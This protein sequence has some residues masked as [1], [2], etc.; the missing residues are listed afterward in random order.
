MNRR[1]KERLALAALSQG[2]MT[3]VREYSSGSKTSTDL[4]EAV[5]RSAD[6]LMNALPEP[7][8]K[9]LRSISRRIQALGDY[10]R[11]DGATGVMLTSFL[12]AEVEMAAKHN[13]DADRLRSAMWRL[14]RYYDRQ[15][16]KNGEYARADRACV[17]WEG[18]A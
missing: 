4:I 18:L 2:M 9:E 10:L 15:L 8:A 1:D 6:N 7:T 17:V 12:V 3:M 14:H 13:K 5:E 11:D 16:D